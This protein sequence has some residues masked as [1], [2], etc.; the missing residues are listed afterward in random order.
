MLRRKFSWLREESNERRWGA[1]PSEAAGEGISDTVLFE[2]RPQNGEQAMQIS[3]ETRESI[4]S[5]IREHSRQLPVEGKG[6]NR[7]DDG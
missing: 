1:L 3:E 5:I 2:Q 4:Y 6:K 7:T